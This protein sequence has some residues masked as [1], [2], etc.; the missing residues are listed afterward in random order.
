MGVQSIDARDVLAIIFSFAA[1][2]SP[3]D[4]TTSTIGSIASFAQVCRYWRDTTLHQSELWSDVH[5]KARSQN[6]LSDN[7]P[8]AM[9]RR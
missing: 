5:L 9:T 7:S 2:P 6:S 4:P 8:D 1:A 3:H